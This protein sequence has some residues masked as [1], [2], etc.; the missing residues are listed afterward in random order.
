MKKKFNVMD[1]DDFDP[2]DDL[3]PEYDLDSLTV[4]ARG[5]AR[6]KAKVVVELTPDVAQFFPDAAS[7][8]E[9]LRTMIRL[10]APAENGL[11][12][13]SRRANQS[14]VKPQPDA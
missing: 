12:A 5:P 3:L 1:D 13:N 11:K 7:V 6:A 8:N 4:V 9:A 14:S 2:Q 10:I